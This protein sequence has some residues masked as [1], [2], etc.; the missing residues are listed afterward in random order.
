MNKKVTII[1]IITLFILVIALVAF[2]NIGNV[3]V[4]KDND[5]VVEQVK[6]E[7]SVET[8]TEDKEDEPSSVEEEV[9]EESSTT[10]LEFD[11]NQQYTDNNF[12]FTLKKYEVKDG[13]YT[14]KFEILNINDIEEVLDYSM[15]KCMVNQQSVDVNEAGTVT[16]DG[17]KKKNIEV[18]CNSDSEDVYLTYLSVMYDGSE[19]L[20]SFGKK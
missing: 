15:F 2:G 19:D 1:L 5:D 9:K 6:K 7:E 4:K 11:V 12:L 14:Y 13:I 20:V 8:V 17:K 3:D 10:S 16:I 18:T